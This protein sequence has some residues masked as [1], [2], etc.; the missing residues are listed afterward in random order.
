MKRA[1][2]IL[3]FTSIVPALFLLVIGLFW[4]NRTLPPPVQT[5]WNEADDFGWNKEDSNTVRLTK[6]RTIPATPY[7]L[8]QFELPSQTEGNEAR[9]RIIAM[10][11]D[12]LQQKRTLRMEWT[13]Y[14]SSGFPRSRNSVIKTFYLSNLFIEE[15]E[16]VLY[17]H[18]RDW[19]SPNWIL[20]LQE[21]NSKW[22]PRLSRWMLRD[23]RKEF[24]FDRQGQ[25]EIDPAEAFSQKSNISNAATRYLPSVREA[26]MNEYRYQ[27]GHLEKTFEWPGSAGR[28]IQVKEKGYFGYDSQRKA[29]SFWLRTHPSRTV[30]V[31]LADFYAL[32]P[33]EDRKAFAS[34]PSLS[35]GPILYDIPQNREY[36]C[37]FICRASR[38]W[39]LFE[40]Q[41][42]EI[43]T[44][45]ANSIF[46]IA[47]R[48]FQEI[49]AMAIH[50][51]KALIFSG[52]VF[53]DYPEEAI[54]PIAPIVL[55]LRP[56]NSDGGWGE[57][58][59]KSQE[60]PFS[61]PPE[62]LSGYPADAEHIL[63]YR[64]QA[65]WTAKWDGSEEKRIFPKFFT[66]TANPS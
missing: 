3:F 26:N 17:L 40:I 36:F 12:R 14:R 65:I 6:L 42:H 46:K 15:G 35:H 21:N 28:L 61:K 25:T 62:Y 5:F 18:Y 30:T 9:T 53:P 1:I 7:I 33:E 66:K 52:D 19:F 51:N 37:L 31:S 2:F 39:L 47:G 16:P 57:F 50:G 64:D 49:P 4:A 13:N 58:S 44:G 56:Q 43:E 11:I 55:S 32:F 48:N 8:C 45:S 60:I 59:A 24:L 23:K 20:A 22:A 10:L 29:L 27:N 63:F 41:D 34:T 38:S 54:S